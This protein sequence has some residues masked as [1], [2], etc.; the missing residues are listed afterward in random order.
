MDCLIRLDNDGFYQFLK[1]LRPAGEKDMPV[2]VCRY[3]LFAEYLHEGFVFLRGIDPRPD[4]SWPEPF[5]PLQTSAGSLK[6]LKPG[7][8]P[9]GGKQ[10]VCV[11]ADRISESGPPG[12]PD[13]PDR[14]NSIPLAAAEITDCFTNWSL[15]QIEECMAEDDCEFFMTFDR[16]RFAE[17]LTVIKPEFSLLRKGE[18]LAGRWCADRLG[19][20]NFGDALGFE[21]ISHDLASV[22]GLRLSPERLGKK[23]HVSKDRY[24]V[25][26][27]RKLYNVLK[28]LSQ[29]S[30]R[31]ADEAMWF[32]RDVFLAVPYFNLGYHGLE[33]RK[34]FRRSPDFL[35]GEPQKNPAARLRFPDG[36]R[37]LR[38]LI[39]SLN[40]NPENLFRLTSAGPE[41]VLILALEGTEKVWHIPY[42]DAEV[43]FN[44]YPDG[45]ASVLF[46]VKVSWLKLA[47]ILKTADFRAVAVD[48]P[49]KGP[50]C[51]QDGNMFYTTAVM[52][53]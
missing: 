53:G 33:G 24:Q 18:W 30:L 12:F 10:P 5:P 22:K 1:A 46:D 27:N 36:G 42:E 15:K 44:C 20:V 26:L 49:S 3:G 16:R 8:V 9:H 37:A 2:Y 28:Q 11:Y 7:G 4:G 34:P 29:I 50:V 47:A 40:P 43:N 35:P 6:S 39:D 48:D 23:F 17:A 14:E 51:F 31:C 38:R 19:L 45:D 41:P 32:G 21:S 13:L 25:L 52:T